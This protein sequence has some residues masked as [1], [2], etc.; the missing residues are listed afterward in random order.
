MLSMASFKR[1][2]QKPVTAPANMAE[3]IES[4]FRIDIT[5]DGAI[6]TKPLV[7]KRGH[8][9]GMLEIFL[10]VSAQ[11]LDEHRGRKGNS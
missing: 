10:A 9:L 4:S 5:G 6:R 3:Q 2:L 11:L 7:V 8:A 1:Q